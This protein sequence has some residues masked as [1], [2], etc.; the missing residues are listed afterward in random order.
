[1]TWDFGKEKPCVCMPSAYTCARSSRD[2]CATE[3]QERR[4]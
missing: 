1:M 3:A 2:I 4:R